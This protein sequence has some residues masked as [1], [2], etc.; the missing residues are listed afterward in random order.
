M[1]TVSFSSIGKPT[2]VLQVIETSLPEPGPG[3][4]RIKVIAS[5][6]NPSDLLFVQNMY[7]TQPEL[8]S[9]TGFEGVGIVDKLGEGVTMRTG[10]RVSFT[11]IGAWSE[12]VLANQRSL[13]PVPDSL[14]DEVAAQL[15]VNPFSAYAMV[16]ESG[17]QPGQWVLLTAA[18]SSFSKLVIQLC[19]MKGIQ[20]I[21]TVRHND[22]DDE[23]KAL[24][25]TEIINTEKEKLTTRVKAITQ[26]RGV[27]CVLEAVGGNTTS[28][29]LKCLAKGGTMLLYGVLSLQ[30]PSLNA[31]LIIFRELT[32][33]GFWLTDWMRRVDSQT[34][35]NVARNVI[36]LLVSG[37]IQVPVEATYA[38]TDLK[39]AIE[40]SER[41]G[42][43]GKILLKA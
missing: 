7:G 13:I 33:K 31:G 21:G 8:P 35:Q 5:P 2:D 24:G 11:A 3:E 12:Y 25:L 41:A 26:G 18:G 17:L 40:H 37:Q 32:I 42:R 14:S 4:V 39:K 20:T 10:I 27:A 1:Q 34:R 43:R 15:F 6:I 38:L 9:G 28:D 23:L 16:E 36:T 30:N 22:L 29:A 19:K